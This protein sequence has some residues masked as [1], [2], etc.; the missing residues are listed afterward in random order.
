MGDII[1]LESIP[2]LAAKYLEAR[3][4]DPEDV[5]AN[6]ITTIS[7]AGLQ[8]RFNREF[9]SGTWGILYAYYGVHGEDR[10]YGTV[11]VFYGT[12]FGQAADKESRKL[13]APRGRP[14]EVY[15]PQVLRWENIPS[16]ARVYLCESVLK[17]IVL[18]KRGIWAVGLNG[19]SGYSSK[20]HS[21]NLSLMELPWEERNLEPVICFDSNLNEGSEEFNEDVLRAAE[22]F[23]AKW[24][25]RFPESNVWLKRIPNSPDGKS[26]GIDDWLAARGDE[27]K[28]WAREEPEEFNI[29]SA[30]GAI[31]EINS[32]Y[33][34]VEDI[35]RIASRE[36]EL[37]LATIADMRN[38]LAPIMYTVEGA[39]GRQVQKQGFD[40][41][42]RST[43][44]N[45]VEKLVFEPTWDK[46]ERGVYLNT[47]PGFA[48]EEKVGPASLWH[49]VL[50]HIF[51]RESDYELMQDWFAH[52]VQHPGVRMTITPLIYGPQGIGKTLMCQ[53]VAKLFGRSA[54]ALGVRHLL[55]DFNSVYAHKC[56]AYVDEVGT[57]RERQR[58]YDTLKRVRTED[59]MVVNA[60]GQQE[61]EIRNTVNWV[62]ITNEPDALPVA[63]D[64][65]RVWI[66]EINEDFDLVRKP[67]FWRAYAE[68][69]ESEDVGELLWV[70]RKRDISR[71]NPNGVAPSSQVKREM[72]ELA[73]SPMESW[74][75][76]LK[77]NWRGNR[78][79]ATTGELMPL[80]MAMYPDEKDMGSA[81]K[82]LAKAMIK[83]GF[84]R[85]NGG[86]KIRHPETGKS[87]RYWAMEKGAAA[88]PLA[89][90][91]RFLAQF[92]VLN[93]GKKKF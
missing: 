92:P 68:W 81:G 30:A 19:V 72:H 35:K 8:G 29:E 50:V 60:K 1:R 36:G 76:D 31:A 48:V 27:F 61:Y 10:K 89:T 26:W 38:W 69:M 86:K 7:T 6:K 40:A 20:E 56:F 52:L 22:R 15:Y 80:Y 87:E 59:T 44:R 91:Q 75:M 53:A 21:L 55:S 65:R 74:A 45:E 43:K 9:P 58:L 28:K 3:G 73:A 57:P 67:K 16:R 12:P 17:S 46:W 18:A 64:D 49:E 83:A 42:L 78:P 14:A 93:H 13:L 39:Q 37:K 33:V 34:Y 85:P 25:A 77:E 2:V 24:R 63:P 41:W 11:R 4:I 82:R 66:P 23:S 51:K 54:V 71:F 79:I 62:L 5:K 88:L 84:K 32:K 70:L 90:I 47:W